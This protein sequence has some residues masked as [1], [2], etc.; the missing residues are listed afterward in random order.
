MY[1]LIEE[2]MAVVFEKDESEYQY[3]FILIALLPLLAN[4]DSNCDVED[5]YYDI[6]KLIVRLW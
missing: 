6:Q 4:Q 5:N 2:I 1:T 3:L